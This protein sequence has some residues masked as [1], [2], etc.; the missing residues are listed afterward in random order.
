MFNLTRSGQFTI[1]TRG[2]YHC[3]T[4]SR[5]ALRY[6]VRASGDSLDSRGFLLDQLDI[7]KYFDSIRETSDSCELLAARARADLRV[8]SVTIRVSPDVAVT[9]SK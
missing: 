5:P 8:D 6:E 2:A 7:P 9:A 3:T 1:E 4:E